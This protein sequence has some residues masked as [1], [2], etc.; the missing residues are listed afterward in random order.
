M[1]QIN[2]T[3]TAD[4]TLKT[5]GKYCED[6]IQIVQNLEEITATPT[7]E[8]QEFV[9]SEGKSGISKVVVNETPTEDVE[10]KST[11]DTELVMPSEG[12][13]IRKVTVKQINLQNKSV[14][15]S[16]EPQTI[17]KDGGFD[18]LK[19]VSVEPIPEEYVVPEGS[20]EITE[21]NTYDVTDKASV[22]VNV[23][24][25]GTNGLQWK[26]D[27]MKSLANE[28]RDCKLANVDG[29]LVG[30]DTTNLKSTESM[31]VNCDNL[32]SAPMLD[33]SHVENTTT[34]FSGCPK[35]VSV[36]E[37][38]L[39]SCTKAQ[40]MFSGC[41]SLTSISLP[42]LADSS[43]LQYMFE[44][45]TALTSV[46]LGT[47]KPKDCT[48][49]FQGCSKLAT[50]PIMDTSLVDNFSYGFQY[51]TSITSAFPF[52]LPLCTNIAYMYQ[53]CTNLT[54]AYDYNLSG[55]T[56]TMAY[57]Y[58]GCSK[59]AEVT[60]RNTSSVRYM[61][62]MFFACSSLTSVVMPNTGS[63]QN[64]QYMFNGCT[65][66]QTVE[67]DLNGIRSWLH[68]NDGMFSG[69]T[70]LTNLTLK[71]IRKTLVI[72]GSNFGQL[73]SVDSLIN[74]LKELWDYS[75]TTTTKTLTMGAT[76]I[77]KLANVYVK[78]ITPTAEQIAED[79][80]IAS[81][82]PCVVCESTDEGAMLIT[83]YAMSKKWNLA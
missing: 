40:S 11:E 13:F 67:L 56:P 29:A 59:L 3:S 82:K 21:N 47:A 46:D 23:A 4:V 51:C 8:V 2:L 38:D 43:N 57:M 44:N 17:V 76:N 1:T 62:R 77:D 54:E 79:P 28:F 26:I 58:Y 25:T 78:L 73:L 10:V 19:M 66:L 75:S 74:T 33:M 22:V 70:N 50:K 12:K 48:H 61:A 16:K 14:T 30:L 18:A 32:T 60:L 72:A 55:E 45:C 71:N 65:N 20:L 49:M 52:E 53:N 83:E 6:D 9:P 34:M 27:N 64:F 7:D 31:C 15:P 69:C 68:Y 42:K 37:Y 63:V 80:N 36:P 5:A 39:S 24:S 81:K 41:S 35:L